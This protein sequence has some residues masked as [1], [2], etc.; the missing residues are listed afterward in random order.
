VDED[1]DFTMKPDVNFYVDRKKDG[2][3]PKF[4]PHVMHLIDG[5][6]YDTPEQLA[7]DEEEVIKYMPGYNF[8]WI[9][10]VFIRCTLSIFGV[11]MFLRLNWMFAQAGVGGALGIIFWSV[12]LTSL[13]T[14]SLSALSTNGVVKGGGVYY[15]VSRSLGAEYGGVVAITLF[16]AQSAAVSLHL[17]GFGEAVAILED[18][19]YVFSQEGDTIFYGVMGLFAVLGSAF[20]G[21]NFEVQSQKVLAVSMALALLMFYIGVFTSTN[22]TTID[23]TPL[24]ASTFADNMSGTYTMGNT[25]LTVFGVFFPACTGIS[26]GSSISGDLADPQVAIPKGTFAAILLTTII[27]VSMGLLLCAVF[28]PEGLGNI[29]TQISAIDISLVAEL[30]YLG[31]F[32]AALSSALA[33]IVGAPRVLMAVAR[34]DIIPQL[35]FYKKSY[36]SAEEPLRGYVTV[37]AIAFLCIT[38]LDLNTVS[39]IVTNFYL[40]QYGLINYSVYHA[41]ISKAPGWRPSFKYWSPYSAMLGAVMCFVSMFMVDWIMALLTILASFALFKYIIWLRPDV[42]W[43][44]SGVAKCQKSAVESIY[45]MERLKDH[46]KNY[47]PQFLLLCKNPTDDTPMISLMTRLKKARAI[48]IVGRVILGDIN[49]IEVFRECERARKDVI[50]VKNDIAAILQVVSAP[51]L[52]S[53]VQSL[54]QL[55]GFGK[56]KPNTVLIGYKTKWQTEPEEELV[57]YMQI[58]RACFATSHAVVILR[59][60]HEPLKYVPF[61]AEVVVNMGE[62]LYRHYLC[63]HALLTVCST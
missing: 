31:M 4:R 43:G 6:N 19:N 38:C 56:L 10:G 60:S 58:L 5:Q 44:D 41:H 22:N 50:M 39:P 53:G 57:E 48:S 7:S 9:E 52:L 54:L 34:D 35:A 46:V 30:M 55:A 11:L 62:S 1:I 63:A 3:K 13:T 23:S 32:A 28:T 8:G 18:G 47:R 20:L 51:S 36:F 27:Y 59:N 40:V 12:T 24:S 37:V 49:D 42:N 21:A 33:L 61:E 14:S 16:I 29:E 17:R 25:W 2:V 15:M 45:R 26:A